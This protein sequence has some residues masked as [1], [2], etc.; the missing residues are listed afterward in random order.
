MRLRK[1]L[2]MNSNIFPSDR[3]WLSL[4][5]ILGFQAVSYALA[6]SKLIIPNFCLF[7]KAVWI[8]FLMFKRLLVVLLLLLKPFCSGVK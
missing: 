6:M 5:V 4:K 3:I 8:S 1:K 7:C 2:F